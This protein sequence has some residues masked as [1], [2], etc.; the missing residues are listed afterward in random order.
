MTTPRWPTRRRGALA[1]S[2][3]ALIVA[4]VVAHFAAPPDRRYLSANVDRRS[5]GGCRRYHSPPASLAHEPFVV[6]LWPPAEPIFTDADLATE[7]HVAMF[8]PTGRSWA[9]PSTRPPTGDRSFYRQPI[10]PVA[11]VVY[12]PPSEPP[13]GRAAKSFRVKGPRPQLTPIAAARAAGA[14]S[15]GSTPGPTPAVTDDRR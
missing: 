14:A 5:G 6:V 9:R 2:A 15:A 4:V 7:R 1:G 11:V 3:V 10:K 8:L 13:E 12:D